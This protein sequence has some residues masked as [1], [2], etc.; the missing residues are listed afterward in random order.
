MEDSLLNTLKD[1]TVP[2]LHTH[3][4]NFPESNDFSV[5]I[6]YEQEEYIVSWFKD[7]NVNNPE[8]NASAIKSNDFGAPEPDLED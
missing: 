5:V 7:V 4:Q 1:L 6:I 3:V 8:W 2:Q